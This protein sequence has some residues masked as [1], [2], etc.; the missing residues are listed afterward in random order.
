MATRDSTLRSGEGVKIP[1]Y[2]RRKRLINSGE[3]LC[4]WLLAAAVIAL[5]ITLIPG[6]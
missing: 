1:S 2:E 3:I 4:A 6:V 5:V